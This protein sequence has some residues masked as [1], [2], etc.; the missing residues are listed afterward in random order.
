MR[1]KSIFVCFFGVI[2]FAFSGSKAEYVPL[3][4]PYGM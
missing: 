1:D 4:C 2:F 3:A